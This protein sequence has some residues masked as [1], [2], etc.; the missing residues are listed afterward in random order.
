M[1][2]IIDWSFEGEWW[3]WLYWTFPISSVWFIG[4]L[5]FFGKQ[6]LVQGSIPRIVFWTGPIIAA[7]SPILIGISTVL[8]ITLLFLVAAF[9]MIVYDPANLW[10]GLPITFLFWLYCRWY[11]KNNNLAKAIGTT[12]TPWL[13]AMAITEGLYL[14]ASTWLPRTQ[15]HWL[16]FTEW[17]ASKI[18]VIFEN[19]LPRFYSRKFIYTNCFVCYKY[20]SPIVNCYDRRIP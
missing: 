15:W 4:G 6:I 13:V 11:K 18:D 16:F 9:A 17:I 20:L 3:Y 7:L 5:A 2:R 8:I 10:A 19:V 12:I 1:N 14:I